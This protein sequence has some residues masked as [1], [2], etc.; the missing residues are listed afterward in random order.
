MRTLMKTL[1]AVLLSLPVAVR[2]DQAILVSVR[3]TTIY[4][5]ANG[6]LSNG[7]GNRFFSGRKMNFGIVDRGLVKFDVAGNIPCGATI[8]GASLRLFMTNTNA[9]IA[10]VTLHRVLADWGEAGSD[11]AGT[12]DSAQL[13]DAT[14]LHTFFNTSFWAN[15][16]GDFVAAASGTQMVDGAGF[17]DWASTP[18]MIADVQ[19]WLDD[20][21]TDFG[22]IVIGDENAEFSD[23]A[24]A[25]REHDIPALRPQLIVT[26]DLLPGGVHTDNDGVR[27]S[28]DAEPADPNVCRDL[29]QDGCDDCSMTGADGSGG[30]TFND[31]PDSDADGA[32]DV[33]DNCLSDANADQTDTDADGMGDA[34]DDDDD[35]DGVLDVDDIQPQNPFACRDLDQD[36]CSDCAL[37]RDDGS[38]GD[39]SND[40]PD[41]D[42]DGVCDLG[43]DDDDND[44]VS[45]VDDTQPQ[46]PFAC[47]DVD[48]DGCD[49]CSVTGADG[50]GGDAFHDGPD[51]DGDGVCDGSDNCPGA[52][53]V[54]QVDTDGDGMG[55]V[56]EDGGAAV[57]DDNA[58]GD[59]S[60]G[61]GD[62]ASDV[63]QGGLFSFC[64]PSPMMAMSATLLT[65]IGM[66]VRIRRRARRRG[67]A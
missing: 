62:S 4:E 26:Y 9:P 5:N 67:R 55:D 41:A 31:G 57:V 48:Q 36:G 43:D 39:P 51:T 19:T 56:C 27:D 33:S 66:T 61:V 54:N 28:C 18:E 49:D 16:G 3:D 63:P 65:L 23:K 40:G 1:A 25:T 64:G 7:S 35:N 29:D 59:N 24:Y 14:W 32:C 53:N 30:D 12:G 46:D 15:I 10:A 21:S 34:C 38:G 52:A 11:G 50:S 47:R 44:G 8:Q 45:D 58:G 60:A 22:W 2:A 42:G 37:T 20:P 6:S 13:G 17:Y